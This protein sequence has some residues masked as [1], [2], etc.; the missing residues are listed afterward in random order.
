MKKLLLLIL[1]LWAATGTAQTVGQ[2]RY[3][4]TKFLKVGGRNQVVIENIATTDTTL[5]KPVGIDAKGRILRLPYWPTGSGSIDY[6]VPGFGVKVDSINRT[7]TVSADTNMLAL[8]DTI[9]VKMP[10][11][12]SGDTLEFLKDSSYLV[13]N[14][15]LKT[16]TD[17]VFK[18]INGVD[19]FAFLLPSGGGGGGTQTI[20]VNQIGTLG[21]S[22]V[23]VKNDSTLNSV[24]IR[25]SL[26]IITGYAPDGAYYIQADTSYLKSVLGGSAVTANQVAFGDGTNRM[27]SDSALRFNP[28]GLRG[29]KV[30]FEDIGTEIRPRLTANSDGNVLVGL[31]IQPIY[32]PLSRINT[33]RQAIKINDKYLNID[34]SG[35][36]SVGGVSFNLPKSA[37]NVLGLSAGMASGNLSVNMNLLGT[38]SGAGASNASN[39][40]FL[41]YYAG[42]AATSA[43]SSNFLGYYAGQAA[44]SA[45]YSLF[46][47]Y[48]AGAGA[49]GAN[50]SVFL[51]TRTGQGATGANNSTFI[52]NNVGYSSK[53]VITGS[54]NILIG[55]YITTPTASSSNMLSLGNVI[56]ATNMHR[57]IGV[58]VNEKE[59]VNGHVGINNAFPDSSAAL[60]IKGY[61]YGVLIPRLTTNSRL[62]ITTGI[63][64]GTIGGGSGYTPGTYT[65]ISFTGGSG[66]GFIANLRVFGNGIVDIVTPMSP[67]YNYK[68]GDVLTA[69][70]IGAGSGFTYTVTSLQKAAKGLLVMDS[71][72]NK[73]HSFN[74]DYWVPVGGL[75]GAYSD[76]ASS[77]ST[78]TVT[79]G[80]TLENSLY[81]IQVTPTSSLGAA[82]YYVTNKTS[83]TFDV[84]YLSPLTGTLTFD[85]YL[86]Y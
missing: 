66:S 75:S 84:T 82:P 19:S 65:G 10:L 53:H 46:S 32:N 25:D 41:G 11:Y 83:T 67:G 76:A 68:I 17:S 58:D 50:N 18:T 85:W 27:T 57:V 7:Y 78:F 54:N 55:N 80:T 35:V 3:D 37:S 1:V 36:F 73:L 33:S 81:K 39:S 48:Y 79:I 38:G 22:L 45:S 26:G 24:R 31:S 56:Y 13:K 5:S 12:V 9:K 2:F 20:Y 30:G 52:G 29:I 21:D 63:A 47:G 42:Q 61:K 51:G 59:V 34:S 16:G 40:N 74:G 8:K 15:F 28:T 23:W 4:T 43:T 49:T 77:T 86:S 69:S 60:D 62:S 6:V 71:T 14:V 70:G 72:L 64:T 44:T